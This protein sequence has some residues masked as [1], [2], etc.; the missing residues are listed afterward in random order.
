MFSWKMYPSIK[1]HFQ[2]L[3]CK[4]LD[5][6]KEKKIHYI[7]DKIGKQGLNRAFY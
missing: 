5:K 7:V 4:E 3:Y 1:I 6:K 2:E